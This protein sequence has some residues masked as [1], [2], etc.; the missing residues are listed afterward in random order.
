[1]FKYLAVDVDGTITLHADVPAL[2]NGR[3]R[4]YEAFVLRP[5]H[6]YESALYEVNYIES[7]TSIAWK[8]VR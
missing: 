8:R 3:W 7:R 5:H 1:M 6:T 2:I 4:D